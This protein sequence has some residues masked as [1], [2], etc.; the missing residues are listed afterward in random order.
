VSPV[1]ELLD[2]PT[3]LALL[4]GSGVGRLGFS[5]GGLP[6]IHPLNY[7]LAGRT[8]VFR[9]EDGEKARLA[10][11]GAVACLEVD[12]TDAMDHAGWSVLA[13]G[14]LA[15]VPEER[16][17]A[18]RRLPLTAWASEQADVFVELTIELL[19]G[20]SISPSGSPVDGHPVA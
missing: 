16:L 5:S 8:A 17:P 12:G 3:C 13:T 20:R 19:T 15:L 18:A 11:M 10:Q 6:V 2:E 14:R 9:C 1:V 4:A 7:H